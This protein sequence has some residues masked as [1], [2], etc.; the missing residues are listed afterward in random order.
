MNPKHFF[1]ILTFLLIL[2]IV[3]AQTPGLNKSILLSAEIQ[4]DPA[5]IT[6]FWQPVNGATS[7][8]IYRKL[9]NSNQWGF[10]VASNLPGNTLS[11]TDNTVETGV[12]Y[13]YRIN[14]TGTVAGSGYIL[15]GIELTEVYDR[16]KVLLVYDTISTMGLE[17]EIN[18]WADDVVGDGFQVIPIPVDQSDAV[19]SVKEKIRNTY[20][21]DPENTRTLFLL[22]RVPVPYSGAIV[23]DGHTPD[24]YGAWPADGYYAELTSTWTDNTANI[25]GASTERNRNVPGDGKFDQ[26]TFPSDLELA[27]GRVDMHNLPAFADHETALLKK[28]LDK[29]HAF[30]NKLFIAENR[31]LVDD[32]F[33]GYPEGFSAAGW[34][35]F[36]ALCGADQVFALD[37]STT[38]TA[39][40]YLWSY[41]CGA[42][43][44]QNC[45]G[46]IG[47][48]GFAQNSVLGVFTML[49]GSYFG[50][51]DNPENNLL[52]A[53]L[54]SG[55]VL[56]N[57]WAGRPYWYFHH[58]G[59]GETVGY[60][61]LASMNNSAL[62][63]YNFGQKGVHMALMGDPTLRAHPVGPVDE[64]WAGAEAGYVTLGWTAPQ[65]DVE[66]FHI[67]RKAEDEAV[68]MKIN[69]ELV[70]KENIYIDSCLTKPGIYTY[71]VR[72][73]VL[74]KT[75][76]GSYYNMGTGAYRTVDVTKVRPLLAAFSFE[77]DDYRVSFSNHSMNA[78][79]FFWDF[80]DGNS[81]EET[82]PQHEYALSGSYL[83]TLTAIS[84]CGEVGIQ[85]TIV[86]LIGN[87][88]RS[89]N[90]WSIY[91]NPV[92]NS[93]E[94]TDFTGS[95]P[96]KC[97][98][99]DLH[100]NQ[101]ICVDLTGKYALDVSFLPAGV[102]VLK[103]EDPY[104]PCR[105]FVKM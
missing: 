17:T 56:T 58:M 22:G 86:I 67:F 93:L 69:T 41:G 12:A 27:V 59:M 2:D 3:T 89:G 66:G 100:G 49:F 74:E 23:P 97:R 99:F 85:S 38:L 46:V 35:N 90:D 45:S 18:R 61:A 15:T 13:E 28:Y 102:Y 37:Y 8:K 82:D 64:F 48:P 14:C 83:V 96:R 9:K 33:T 1:L 25:T 78:T 84:G 79:S 16:G 88:D 19:S 81:S 80:G 36:S 47:T 24:H 76:S 54:A 71:M 91:P 57:C 7:F 21:M 94:L 87:T 31:A 11:W 65:A 77:Q 4:K 73:V 32:E 95:T 98:I 103:L 72:T 104:Y 52:R 26:S 63:D 20:L 60:S 50:D 10:P 68:F 75:N 43:N 29:N 53:A 5:Q 101:K 39:E 51:W 42:G 34:R 92:I 6:I 70:G 105:K 55:N 40:S 44:F 62:Y 30:R